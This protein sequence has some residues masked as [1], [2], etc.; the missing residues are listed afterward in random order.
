MLI[1][2]AFL[3]AFLLLL[4]LT[5]VKGQGFDYQ[6]KKHSVGVGLG[7]FKE[8]RVNPSSQFYTP[9]KGVSLYVNYN[10][11]WTKNW[12]V[13]AIFHFDYVNEMDLGEKSFKPAYQA[14]IGREIFIGQNRRITPLI[15]FAFVDEWDYG[16]IVT[17]DQNGNPL[18][19]EYLYVDVYNTPYANIGMEYVERISQY[20]DV[21]VRVDMFYDFYGFGRSDFTGFLRIKL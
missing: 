1:R 4:S 20:L 5:F 15:G 6:Y 11:K 3:M 13:Q 17:K 2:R 12:V 21:G 8:W 18:S 7:P 9:N 10:F 16:L 19:I 14:S